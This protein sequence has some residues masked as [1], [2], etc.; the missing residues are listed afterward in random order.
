MIV[1]VLKFIKEKESEREREMGAEWPRE[2]TQKSSGYSRD[3]SS[4]IS[5]FR[6]GEQIKSARPR[7]MSAPVS[8]S[9]GAG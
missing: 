7:K 6:L 9:V 1:V 8:Q 3:A 2:Y 5:S 4:T